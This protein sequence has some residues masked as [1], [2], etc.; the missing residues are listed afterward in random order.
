MKYK[1][2]IFAVVT[3]GIVA[4]LA[5]RVSSQQDPP[6]YTSL[7]EV[8]AKN[9]EL[10]TRL[11]EE[12]RMGAIRKRALMY[13]PETEKDYVSRPSNADFEKFKQVFPAE[14]VENRR[15]YVVTSVSSHKIIQAAASGGVNWVAQD[16]SYFRFVCAWY[17]ELPPKN[18][19]EKRARATSLLGRPGNFD[20]FG[21]GDFEELKTM[22]RNGHGTKASYRN[23]HCVCQLLGHYDDRTMTLH[24][25]CTKDDEAFSWKLSRLVLAYRIRA[26]M[27]P[28]GEKYNLQKNTDDA[29]WVPLAKDSRTRDWLKVAST[30]FS[31]TFNVGSRHIELVA[32]ACKAR[33]DGKM[34]D[35]NHIIAAD[36][37]DWYIAEDDIVL[38]MGNE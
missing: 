6:T 15:N 7:Q 11:I 19:F 37:D 18:D 3:I 16:G 38:L 20:E 9:P 12:S 13:N 28:Q 4:F 34:V 8:M 27:E 10:Y 1:V 33:V 36:N 29:L 23:Y 21:A 14:L 25:P 5:V 2:A 24:Q 31:R 32:G 17:Y 26:A 35:L 22:G 30:D